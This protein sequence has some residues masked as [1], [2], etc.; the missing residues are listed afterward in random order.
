MATN[1]KGSTSRPN[2]G[3]FLQGK[4]ALKVEDSQKKVTGNMNRNPIFLSLVI[5]FNDRSDGVMELLTRASK[6]L[7]ALV[8]DYEI[9]VVNNVSADKT[10]EVLISLTGANGLPNLQVFTLTKTVDFDTASWV[11]CENCL[12]DFVA[13]LDPDCDDVEFLC[14][15]LKDVDTHE[16]VFAE[17]KRRSRGKNLYS[18][19]A[20]I[21]YKLLRALHGSD[22]RN[23]TPAF[24]L[25]SR[26]VINFLMQHRQPAAAHRVLPMLAGFRSKVLQY[27]SSQF[28]VKKESFV[29]ALHRGLRLLTNTSQAPIRIMSGLALFGATLN[30]IYSI[31]VVSIYFVKTD[32]APGWVSLSLQMSGMFFLVC[33]VL[34]ILGEY[35]AQ[36]SSVVNEA[37]DYLISSE[38][39]SL[40]IGS[41]QRL[42]VEDTEN[43]EVHSDRS[44]DELL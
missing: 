32:V 15:M 31:Y 12:G 39:T 30:V 35:I 24:R 1:R 26:R 21:F 37:P 11:G 8:V 2:L 10:Q 17:N 25:M 19:G 42:N 14:E 4:G 22:F 6:L 41:Q 34:I 27:E 33:C 40:H 5:V 23:D 9:I 18:F 36:I 28:S 38:L 7:S 44:E 16:I 43:E 29:S 20:A 13:I 3:E